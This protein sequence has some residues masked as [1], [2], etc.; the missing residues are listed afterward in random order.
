MHVFYAWV[1]FRATYMK[2]KYILVLLTGKKRGV[3]TGV[4]ILLSQ[5]WNIIIEL[6]FPTFNLQNFFPGA[7]RIKTT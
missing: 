4:E 6:Y 2:G 1:D 5:R 3:K 7:L